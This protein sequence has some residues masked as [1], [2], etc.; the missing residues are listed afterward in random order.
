MKNWKQNLIIYLL[1]IIVFAFIACNDDKNNDD[2]NVSRDQITTISILGGVSSATV[3]GHMTNAQWEGVAVKIENNINDV[4]DTA[5]TEGKTFLEEVFTN[6]NVTIIVEVIPNGYTNFKTIGDGKTI[7]IALSAVDTLYVIDGIISIR[8][9]G[10]RVGN[11][12]S[13]IVYAFGG[14]LALNKK[15]IYKT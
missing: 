1:A 15:N 8:N 5:P 3:R 2:P 7:Y 11:L 6:S 9:N 13:K 14:I 10:S 4:Y 12:K